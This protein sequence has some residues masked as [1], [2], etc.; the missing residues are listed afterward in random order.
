MKGYLEPIPTKHRKVQDQFLFYGTKLRVIVCQFGSLY[1][2]VYKK[3][4]FDSPAYLGS[5]F[6]II[7]FIEFC[8][9]CN[10]AGKKRKQSLALCLPVL[11]ETRISPPPTS[12]FFPL[13]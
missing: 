8:F 9:S 7:V 11:G 3:V 2:T 5:S 1:S 6:Q 12:P 13:L 10:Y 4:E